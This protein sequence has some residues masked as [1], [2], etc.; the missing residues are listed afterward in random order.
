LIAITL[1]NLVSVLHGHLREPNHF[2]IVHFFPDLPMG[3][4]RVLCYFFIAEVENFGSAL[5][6][7]SLP[8]QILPRKKSFYNDQAH[9]AQVRI[10]LDGIVICEWYPYL[11]SQNRMVVR[12]E[13]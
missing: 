13:W 10:S 7:L 1:A 6:W 9:A 11:F 12:L 4:D 3:Q 5:H 2:V 8:D